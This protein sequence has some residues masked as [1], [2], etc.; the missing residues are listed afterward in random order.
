MPVRKSSSTA[1]VSQPTLAHEKQLLASQPTVPP[2]RMAVKRLAT[3]EAT[4]RP[5]RPAAAKPADR[6]TGF[7]QIFEEVTADLSKDAR[8]E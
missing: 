6:S 5:A 1:H 2:P 8:A 7:S 3:A 4:P